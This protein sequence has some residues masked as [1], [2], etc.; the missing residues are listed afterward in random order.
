ML[1]AGAGAQ[2]QLPT[3]PIIAGYSD[4]RTCNFSQTVRSAQHGVNVIIWSAINL[5][6]DED[7]G[8]PSIVDGPDV[9]CVAKVAAALDAEGLRTT[10]LISIGGWNKPHPSTNLTGAEWFATF[11]AWNRGLPRPYEGLDWDLE[12]ADNKSSSNNHFTVEL[13]HLVIDMSVAA[14]ATGYI[15]TMVP[16]QSYLDPTSSSFDLSLLNFYSDWHP[17]FQYHGLNA[18]AYLL[19]AAPPRTFELVT[20][21]L[22]ESWSRFDELLLQ[23]RLPGALALGRTVAPY[24]AGWRVDFGQDPRLRINGSKVVHVEPQQ[25]LLGLSFGSA[26]GKMAFLWPEEVGK[27]WTATEPSTRPRGFAYWNLDLDGSPANGTSTALDM[28]AGLNRF[29]KVREVAQLTV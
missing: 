5:L 20:V 13:L 14:R 26:D 15:V 9:T 24:L 6:V 4:W 11:D 21:Q 17:D 16:A 27:F 19:A 1:L 2:Y 29:L 23:T 25:L 18:Y 22:Y 28:A 3:G 10:H 12:G 7:T 8:A